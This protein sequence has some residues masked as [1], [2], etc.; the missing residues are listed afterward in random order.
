MNAKQNEKDTNKH[1]D[2]DVCPHCGGTGFVEESRGALSYG[3]PG[4][5]DPD[6]NVVPCQYCRIKNAE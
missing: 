5:G 2:R 1:A 6:P 4:Y 3:D